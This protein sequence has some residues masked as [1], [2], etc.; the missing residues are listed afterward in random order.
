MIHLNELKAQLL[1]TPI[2]QQEYE[3]ADMEYSIVEKL[4]EARL[5]TGLPKDKLLSEKVRHNLLLRGWKV[6]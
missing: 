4:I 1:Q 6:V 3:Q 5:A 2:F